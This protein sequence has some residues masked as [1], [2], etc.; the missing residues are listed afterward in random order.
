MEIYITFFLVTLFRRLARIQIVLICS[1][2]VMIVT[3]SS[4][5]ANVADAAAMPV[6]PSVEVAHSSTRPNAIS[7]EVS[8]L[9]SQKFSLKFDVNRHGFSFSNWAGLTPEDSLTYANMARLFGA[10]AECSEGPLDSNCLL[11]SGQQLDLS[12]ANSLITSG[13]CEGMV[14][15]AGLLFT[16]PKE[17]KSIDPLATTAIQLTKEVSGREIAYY[18]LSQILPPIRAFTKRTIVKPP[19]I[20]AKEI[21]FQIRNKKLV[22]LGIYGDGFGHSVLPIRVNI[23]PRKTEITVYDPNFPRQFK[24]LKIN[25]ILGNWTYDKALLA[26]GTIGPMKWKGSGRLDYVPVYLRP[27]NN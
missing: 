21:A 12:T 13:R 2:V 9:P 23:S 1:L 15:L 8:R 7:V 10:D 11:R 16:K 14:V 18:S 4:H 22:S 3:P 26:D 19:Y 20:L 25:N 17:I 5:F 24:T 27:K 6:S